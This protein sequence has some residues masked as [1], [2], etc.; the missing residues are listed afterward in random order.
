MTRRIIAVLGT[1]SAI[2]AS[3]IASA[4]ELRTVGMQTISSA[5]NS[6]F[7]SI[8]VGKSLVVDLQ[9]DAAEAFV[10]NPKTVLIT[11]RTARRIYL[12]GSEIGQTSVYLFA[13]DG[14]QIGGLD[15]NVSKSSE[16]HP[17]PLKNYAI[18]GI[19]IDIYRGDKEVVSV[20]CSS[21]KCTPPPEKPAPENSTVINST[22]TSAMGTTSGTSVSGTTSSRP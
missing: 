1:I 14:R 5:S 8:G 10:G 21:T 6:E 11:M 7:A 17:L 16:L 9:E 18:S 22:Y 2:C 19:G 15:I 20:Y 13:K 12:T 4:S 3:S